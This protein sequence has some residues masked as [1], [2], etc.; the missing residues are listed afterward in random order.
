MKD[1]I[2]CKI[3]D[4]KTASDIVFEDS[5]VVAFRDIDPKAPV[6]IVLIPKEHIGK[7]TDAPDG[8]VFSGIFSAVNRIV[9]DGL[10]GHG[11]DLVNDGF[12]VVVNS[13]K[14]GG[15]AVEHLHFH[16]LG[17]RQMQWPPG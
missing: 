4:K 10:A 9:R 15:Q 11:S 17:G 2:F 12:R 8:S 1:C 14:H 7:V 5:G 13:G 6:H 16:L 3:A